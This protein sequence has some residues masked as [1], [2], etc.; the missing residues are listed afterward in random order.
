MRKECKRFINLLRVATPKCGH[1]TLYHL[2][3]VKVIIY[4]D[5]RNVEPFLPHFKAIYWKSFLTA[6]CQ[7]DISN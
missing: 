1:F 4:L 3:K 6:R 7:G 5:D 2:D